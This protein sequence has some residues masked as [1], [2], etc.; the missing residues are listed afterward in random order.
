MGAIAT[1]PVWSLT[2]HNIRNVIHKSNKPSMY[3]LIGGPAHGFVHEELM[4]V[5]MILNYCLTVLIAVNEIVII[6]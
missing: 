5:Q 6:C 3:Y 4:L 2:I 1:D